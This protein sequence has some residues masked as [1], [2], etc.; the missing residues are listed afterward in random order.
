MRKIIKILI[1]IVFLLLIFYNSV[2]AKKEGDSYYTGSQTVYG[3]DGT[4]IHIIKTNSDGKIQTDIVGA[5][6]TG[7]NNIGNI[8]IASFK[9]REGSNALKFKAIRYFT[10][11]KDAIVITANVGDKIHITDYK[12]STDVNNKV[13]LEFD[14]DIDVLIDGSNFIAGEE[15]VNNLSGEIIGKN[16]QD[17]LITSRSMGELYITVVYWIE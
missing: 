10:A 14:D 16:G 13:I 15:L 17:L 4:N 8:N 3:S 5:L 2:L 12:F 1:G 6:P 7:T 9:G 11:Q